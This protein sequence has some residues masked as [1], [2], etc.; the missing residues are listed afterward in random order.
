MKLYL[1]SY[2]VP[3]PSDLFDL[4]PNPPD[5]IKT[6]IIPNGKDYELPHERGV[7]LDELVND[8][9]KLGPSTEIVDLRDH[10]DSA[11]VYESLK[12]FDFIWVAGGNC[13]VLRSEMRRSGF[14]KIIEKLLGEGK[15]YGGESAGAVVAGLTLQGTE[16]ADE[17]ELADQIIWEGL[18]LTSRIIS[19]HADNFDFPEYTNHMR[20]LYAGEGR[21]LYLNDNQAFVI[22]DGNERVTTKA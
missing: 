5:R 13:F 20:K 16:V 15:V 19:P 4:F 2:R 8:L 3:T 22:N 11:Q 10:D 9:E 14:D 6:A 17:P 12:D 1:S 21:V 18:A 7:K